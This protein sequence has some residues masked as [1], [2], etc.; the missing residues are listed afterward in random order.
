MN[1]SWLRSL[2]P[3][4]SEAVWGDASHHLQ[5]NF[6]RLQIRKD[7]SQQGKQKEG[8]GA[9][10]W[11]RV[12]VVLLKPFFNTPLV[13]WCITAQKENIFKVNDLSKFVVL[14]WREKEKEKEAKTWGGG[15]G[16]GKEVLCG[17]WSRTPP[18]LLSSDW[19]QNVLGAWAEGRDG[20]GVGAMEWEVIGGALHWLTKRQWAKI[21]PVGREMAQCFSYILSLHQ[22]DCG[23]TTTK[24]EEDICFISGVSLSVCP[25]LSTQPNFPSLINL[26][27]L[28]TSLS[29]SPRPVLVCLCFLLYYR[30]CTLLNIN[31]ILF[32]FSDNSFF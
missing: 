6:T 8:R 5:L 4:E 32:M 3:S 24:K 20:W 16:G 18:S 31:F 19:R 22:K 2:N 25:F 27:F 13:L 15:K 12:S 10:G 9:Y 17:R 7:R 30:L 21:K 14:G 29:T 26:N 23:N 1:I 28:S 11:W